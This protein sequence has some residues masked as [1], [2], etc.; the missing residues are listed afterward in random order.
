[1][2]N[3][4]KRLGAPLERG[5][6]MLAA[7]GRWLL[8]RTGDKQGKP[9]DVANQCGP[10]RM[11]VGVFAALLGSS[12]DRWEEAKSIHDLQAPSTNGN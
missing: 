2:H 9:L 3:E 7:D 12:R 6:R 4:I 1:M 8:G 5:V 10:L 11:F